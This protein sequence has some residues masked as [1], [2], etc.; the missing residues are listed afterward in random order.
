[1]PVAH[2][3]ARRA[4]GSCANINPVDTE[5]IMSPGGSCVNFGKVPAGDDRHPQFEPRHPEL[6]IDQRA[7]ENSDYFCLIVEN[8]GNEQKQKLLK[9][10]RSKE[11]SLPHMDPHSLPAEPVH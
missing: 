10:T 9:D 4:K 6:N 1:M 3:G 7:A 11:T 5:R 8:L 2:E